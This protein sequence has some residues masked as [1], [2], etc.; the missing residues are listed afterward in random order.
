MSENNTEELLDVKEF[1]WDGKKCNRLGLPWTFTTYSLN[2]DSLFVEKGLWVSKEDEIRLFRINDISLKR[3][4]W[5]KIIGTGDILVDS[6]DKSLP[7]LTLKNIK[8]PREVRNLLSNLVEKAR[9]NSNVIVTD[10][11]GPAIPPRR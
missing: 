7:H 4:F 2:E 5:Q 11:A 9:R 3:T 8:E 1:V 6:S 10:G